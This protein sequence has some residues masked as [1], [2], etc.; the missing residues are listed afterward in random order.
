[1]AGLQARWGPHSTSYLSSLQFKHLSTDSEERLRRSVVEFNRAQHESRK[2]CALTDHLTI[3]WKHTSWKLL[4]APTKIIVILVLGKK[5][6]SKQSRQT[7]ACYSQVLLC[8]KKSKRYNMRRQIFSRPYRSTEK[9]HVLLWGIGMCQWREWK[10][11]AEEKVNF[12]PWRREASSLS[13]QIKFTL[14]IYA[15]YHNV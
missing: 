9:S 12:E 4:S 8:L 15:D 1:M 10:H 5:Q 11:R 14:V 2:G 7:P 6:K 13:K 3:G